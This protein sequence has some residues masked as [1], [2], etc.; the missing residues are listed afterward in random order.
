[1]ND[2]RPP[3]VSQFDEDGNLIAY[4]AKFY[5][6]WGDYD[7]FPAPGKSQSEEGG[8]VGAEGSTRP[9]EDDEF[10]IFPPPGVKVLTAATDLVTA[11]PGSID[12]ALDALDALPKVG[13]FDVA[14]PWPVVRMPEIDATLWE[15]ATIEP[16]RIDSLHATKTSLNRHRM[17]HYITNPEAMEVHRRAFANLY[18]SRGTLVIVDGHHRV[19]ALRLLGAEDAPA[20]ILRVPR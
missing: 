4:G 10:D 19:A 9:P 2:E 12:R 16:V 8:I 3:E 1:M 18:E 7:V 17:R 20:W 13:D 5:G 11:D 6:D 14:A 15:T